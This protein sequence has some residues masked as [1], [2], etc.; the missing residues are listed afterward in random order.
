MSKKKTSTRGKRRAEE[1]EKASKRSRYHWCETEIIHKVIAPKILEAA[2]GCASKSDLHRRMQERYDDSISWN[3][4]SY[5]MQELDMK[6]ETT[7][8][9]VFELGS[10]APQGTPD[11]DLSLPE[12]V[13][14]RTPDVNLGG[15]GGGGGPKGPA[16]MGLPKV[17]GGIALD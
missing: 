11:V 6:V 12:G 10:L 15:V 16:A 3:S 17:H 7:A 13:I 4:L 1:A 9:I 2:Q 14:E 8:R 5:W